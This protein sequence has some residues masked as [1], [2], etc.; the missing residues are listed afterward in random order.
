MKKRVKLSV[1]VLLVMILSLSLIVGASADDGNLQFSV[2]SGTVT[3]SNGQ[4]LSGVRVQ[5]YDVLKTRRSRLS[6]QTEAAS[7]VLSDW[8]RLPVI[9]ILSITINGVTPSAGMTRPAW[10][11]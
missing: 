3:D 5:L 9:P 8:R 11:M 2:L 10:R 4:G 1:S 6:S 7:G